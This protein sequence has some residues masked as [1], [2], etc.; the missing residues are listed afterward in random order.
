MQ[1]WFFLQKG[2]LTLSLESYHE[3]EVLQIDEALDEV[4]EY[5]EME[6]QQLKGHTST[7]I[8]NL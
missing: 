8:D 5:L 7:S 2:G 4:L 1:N 3:M 6:Q